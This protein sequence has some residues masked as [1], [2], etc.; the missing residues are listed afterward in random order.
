MTR[1]V[2]LAVLALVACSTDAPRTPEASQETEAAAP[3]ATRYMP[4]GSE[5]HAA[6]V[7]P[8]TLTNNEKRYC[9]NIAI[10]YGHMR[11]SMAKDNDR[12]AW[13]RMG[14]EAF[15]GRSLPTRPLPPDVDS[16]YTA[17]AL[18]LIP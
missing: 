8:R 18:A 14:C 17:A 2:F 9:Y 7:E 12:R 5:A 6:P 16:A 15:L 4:D 10:T 3:Q 11:A 1:T 13:A